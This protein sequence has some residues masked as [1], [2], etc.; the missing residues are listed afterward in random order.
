MRDLNKEK[1]KLEAVDLDK[2]NSPMEF[3]SS[4]EGQV[5]ISRSRYADSEQGRNEF[6][7]QCMDAE[8][9]SELIEDAPDALFDLD[10]PCFLPT[11]SPKSS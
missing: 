9:E 8:F 1:S 3:L 10:E 4:G 2:S 11:I 7:E 5:S 6:A